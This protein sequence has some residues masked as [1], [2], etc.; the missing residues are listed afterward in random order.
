[1]FASVGLHSG[2]VGVDENTKWHVRAVLFAGIVSAAIVMAE[3]FL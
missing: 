2:F 3:S 1:M